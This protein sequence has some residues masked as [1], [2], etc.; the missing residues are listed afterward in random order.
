MNAHGPGG[1]AEGR[2]RGERPEG[3]WAAATHTHGEALFDGDPSTEPVPPFAHGMARFKERIGIPA[4]GGPGGVQVFNG[5]NGK[6]TETDG[7]TWKVR[8]WADLEIG[9][10]GMPIGDPADFQ[11]LSIHQIGR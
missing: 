9:D 7:T 8:T 1:Y 2:A 3:R 6:A 11:G 4:G 10:D 5:V